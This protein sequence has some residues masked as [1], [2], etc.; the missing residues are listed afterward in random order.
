MWW[1]CKAMLYYFTK[2]AFIPATL[3]VY[4]M[5]C[6][7]GDCQSIMC[8][9]QVQAECACAVRSL[10]FPTTT[11]QRVFILKSTEH[12][13]IQDITAT[14]IRLLID[15]LT[16]ILAMDEILFQIPDILDI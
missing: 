13:V 8:L 9:E 16:F 10:L 12:S 6:A 3:F 15:I 4:T 7:A 11:S 2:H 1:G 5:H 14:K